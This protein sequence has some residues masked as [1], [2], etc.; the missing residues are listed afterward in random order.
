MK[1]VSAYIFPLSKK[2]FES[3]TRRHREIDETRSKRDEQWRYLNDRRLVLFN[4]FSWPC[5]L[6]ATPLN[7][8]LEAMAIIIVITITYI[9]ISWLVYSYTFLVSIVN[10]MILT[11]KRRVVMVKRKN[12][13]THL[14]LT[15]FLFFT[16]RG[17]K[18][19][20]T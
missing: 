11:R 10:V 13:K 6:P 16:L 14:M 15:G 19:K 1:K 17:W 18:G 8:N 7:N 5:P 4:A 9:Q 20:K 2:C 12:R 3:L